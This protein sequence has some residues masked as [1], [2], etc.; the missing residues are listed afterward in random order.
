MIDKIIA[1]KPD[2]IFDI[3]PEAMYAMDLNTNYAR[4]GTCWEY[5]YA[6]SK[7]IQPKS[8]LEIGCRYGGSLVPS[9]I[10]SEEL[11]YAEAW[12]IEQY[13]DNAISSAN[14]RQYYTG[15]AKWEINKINSQ[16]IQE[17]PRWF[18]LIFIDGDHSYEGKMHDLRMTVGKCKYVFIDDAS[19]LVDV[20]RAIYTFIDEIGAD[21]WG[22]KSIIDWATYIPCFRGG[23]IIKY[24]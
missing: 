13:G 24:S 3:I 2:S 20:K 4:S 1:N 12:D 15:H 10:A 6:I 18:D 21:G 17:L 11:E 7:A 14:V 22:R 9:M 19:Y 16:E 5:N 8:Y 23:Y